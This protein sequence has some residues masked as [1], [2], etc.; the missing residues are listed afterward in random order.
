VKS[1]LHTDT[2]T[3]DFY[4][5]IKRRTYWYIWK[6]HFTEYNSY[7]DFKLTWNPKNSIRKD[8]IS[9]IKNAFYKRK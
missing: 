6:I 8:F 2:S 5:S 9:D 7:K 3:F 1:P 4:L